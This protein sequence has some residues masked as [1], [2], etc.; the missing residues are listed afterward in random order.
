M[1]QPP[2]MTTAQAIG[3]VYDWLGLSDT[4][5]LR[6]SLICTRYW[7]MLGKLHGLL[8]ITDR[9]IYLAQAEFTVPANTIEV[10]LA[11][12]LP[13]FGT[14]LGFER[15]DRTS[16]YERTCP[17]PLIA[18]MRDCDQ[19]DGLCAYLYRNSGDGQLSLRFSGPLFDT[20]TFRLWYEPGGFSRPG[21]AEYPMLPMEGM[22]LLIIETANVCLP[23]LL[24]IYEPAVY[25]G[26]ADTIRGEKIEMRRIFD[27]WRMKDPGTGVTRR[28][29]YNE[30]RRGGG[31][32][33]FNTR[34]PTEP[35]EG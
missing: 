35:Y 15:V 31:S 9:T 1:P 13:N 17:V 16:G 23:E 8:Q 24:K 22:N 25:K 33:R 7:A 32:S 11:E 2:G 10:V 34:L 27:L 14:P 29:A 19:V 26:Y 30:S 12:Q 21:L 28:R 5:V 4:R 6:P 18:D 3:A 20:Y